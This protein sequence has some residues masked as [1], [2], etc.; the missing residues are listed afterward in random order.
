MPESDRVAVFDNDGTLWCEKPMPIQPDFILRAWSR[1]QTRTPT[2]GERQPWKAAAE[3]DYGWFSRSGRALRGRRHE[4]QAL[5]AGVLAPSEESASRLSPRRQ[6][7]PAR[8]AI[9]LSAVATS[10]AP[11]RRWS[12]CSPPGGQRLL[13]LHRLRRRPRLHASDHPRGV[14]RTAERVIGSSMPCLQAGRHGG[15]S[16]AWPRPTTRRRAGEAGA[17]LVADRTTADARRGNSNGDVPMLEFTQH[18]DNP[19][20][21]C[22]SC[23]TTPSANSSTLPAPS[24]ALSEGRR[25]A[26]TVASIREDWDRVF[27]GSPTRDEAHWG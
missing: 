14:R 6:R 2:L 8:L 23:T 21:G 7:V 27:E 16:C 18:G 1:W 20:C 19:S 4:R 17:D 10:N 26:W 12:S 5:A 22:W 25:G 13:E 9:P 24:K 3:R 15:T 11:T